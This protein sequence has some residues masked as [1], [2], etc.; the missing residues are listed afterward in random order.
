MTYGWALVIIVLVIGVLFALG[1][2]NVGS[3]AGNRIAGFTSVGVTAY[4]FQG[5]DLTVRFVNRAGT[6]IN[7]SAIS[8]TFETAN[9]STSSGI[10]PFTLSSGSASGDLL[11]ANNTP[12]YSPNDYYSVQLQINYT[13][14]KTGF[15]YTDSGTLSGKAV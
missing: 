1:I 12:G 13:D 10:S 2:F 4:A 9:T 5:G 15:N 7:V 6:Q 14:L 11:I 3:F 8:Y